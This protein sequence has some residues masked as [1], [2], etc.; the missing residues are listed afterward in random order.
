MGYLQSDGYAGYDAAS[1]KLKLIQL[2][3]WDHCRRKF[4]EAQAAQPGKTQGRTKADIALDKIGKLYRIE[5]EI[6]TLSAE[7]KRRQRQ[8]RSLPVLHDLKRWGDKNRGKSPRDALISKALVYMNNQW[9]KLIRYS[10]DGRLPISNIKAENAIRP[11]VIGRKNWLFAD[12]PKGAHAS[13]IFYSLIETAKANEIEPYAYLRHI[14]KA[15]P[16]ADTVEKVEA[17]LPWNMKDQMPSFKS[18][19]KNRQAA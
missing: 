6:K 2:G 15:L 13:G 3:C 1:T 14:F 10:E 4:K 12:T 19:E 7:E 17:L 8:Q 5:R 9:P 16:Y 11:F 18:N